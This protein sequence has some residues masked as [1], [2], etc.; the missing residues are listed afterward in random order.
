MKRA[1]ALAL[2]LLALLA[3]KPPAN[4]RVPKNT[5]VVGL[6]I[7]DSFRK[8]GYFD[9]AMRYAALYIYAHV[10]G[11]GGLKQTT[12]VFVGSP[13]GGHL[14]QANKLHPVP[15]PHQKTA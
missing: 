8:S 4:T 7:S 5:L 10:N 11:I 1:A 2:A 13:R 6:D 15:E 9:E 12:D 3:C 14:R